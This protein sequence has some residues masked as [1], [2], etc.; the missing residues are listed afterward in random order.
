M[1]TL[2]KESFK[3]PCCGENQISEDLMINVEILRRRLA[4]P[5]VITSGYRCAKHNAEV[6]G[7]A[8]SAHTLG[9]AADLKIENSGQ[10]YQMLRAIL[11]DELFERVE[12]A[13]WWIHVDIDKGKP[14]KVVFLKQ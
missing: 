10:R 3:C 13:P 5:I 8:G 11:A 7:V 12:D 14:Q 1:Q 6:G 9:L 4:F 2:D